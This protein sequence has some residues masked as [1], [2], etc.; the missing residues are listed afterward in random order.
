MAGITKTII[1][2]STDGLQ[3]LVADVD[4]AGAVTIHTAS[5]T[6]TTDYITLQANSS[7]TADVV[8]T[9]EWGDVDPVDLVKV[10]IPKL[11]GAGD[12]E[13]IVIFNK[14][15]TNAK[16]VKAFAAVANVIKISG[17]VNK[18]VD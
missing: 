8:L 9:I 13:K 18:V 6:G 17:D 2:G 11:G 1:S 16:V 3:I 5:A 15:L 14:P 4:T 7:H 10:T 12:G